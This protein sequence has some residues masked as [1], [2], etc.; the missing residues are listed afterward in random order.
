M[1]VA[2]AVARARSILPVLVL[3]TL[4]CQATDAPRLPQDSDDGATRSV[5]RSL[6][7]GLTVE[8]VEASAASVRALAVAHDGSRVES[9]SIRGESAELALRVPVR[10]LDAVR[11]ELR[12]LGEVE[13]DEERSEDV[14]TQRVDVG[15]RARSARAEEER[16]LA[17]LREDT[18]SLADVLAVEA[19]LTTVRERIELLEASERELGSR[20][21]LAHVHVRLSTRV[22]PPW[23]RPLTTLADA[24]ELGVQAAAGLAVGLTAFVVA[25]APVV[26]LLLAALALVVLPVRALGRRR[27]RARLA[28]NAANGG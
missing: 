6:E 7:L 17:M 5:V 14:T 22:V 1:S 11:S 13:R 26:A 21:E 25:A 23:A 18:A 2:R 9:A 27:T 20:V 3:L 24:A 4:G 16:L 28:A 19:R 15:A 10:E 8:D 12:A